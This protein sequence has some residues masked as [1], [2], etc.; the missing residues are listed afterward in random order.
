VPALR[1][2][3]SIVQVPN[4]KIFWR[5]AELKSVPEMSAATGDHAFPENR[6]PNL[7]ADQVRHLGKRRNLVREMN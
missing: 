7:H 5:Q 6:A 3:G 2:S 4:F 1:L